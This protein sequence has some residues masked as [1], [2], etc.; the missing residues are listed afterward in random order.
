MYMEPWS[1]IFFENRCYKP[2]NHQNIHKR[3]LSSY[4]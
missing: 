1:I 3:D 4:V 2:Q